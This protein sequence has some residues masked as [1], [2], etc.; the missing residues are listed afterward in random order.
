MKY[1]CNLNTMIL[2]LMVFWASFHLLHFCF[3]NRPPKSTIIIIKI[4]KSKK[5]KKEHFSFSK[6]SS[7]TAKYKPFCLYWDSSECHETRRTLLY[8]SG[9]AL[10]LHC[11]NT[12]PQIT[13]RMLVSNGFINRTSF[14]LSYYWLVMH[15]VMC[16]IEI[17]WVYK[18]SPRDKKL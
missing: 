13:S 16:L 10:F 4:N 6:S 18:K 5:K 17:L 15:R 2:I 7:A 1:K 3:L 9:G 12:S 8:F 11:L 14:K